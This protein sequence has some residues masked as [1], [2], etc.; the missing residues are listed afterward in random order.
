VRVG[1][2]TYEPLP[3]F[4]VALA[5]YVPIVYALVS[6]QRWVERRQAAA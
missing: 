4:F 6:A 2:E 5:I 1:A 3:P